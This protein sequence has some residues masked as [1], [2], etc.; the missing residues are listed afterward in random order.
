[1]YAPALPVGGSFSAA[2]RRADAADGRPPGRRCVSGEENGRKRADG[3]TRLRGRSDL[4]RE[5]RAQ[6][7]PLNADF[8]AVDPAQ[9]DALAIPGGPTPEYLRL[10]ERL[11]QIVRHFA[12][13]NKPLAAICHAAQILVAAGVVA[14]LRL[15]GLPAVKPGTWSRAGALWRDVNETF[16]NAVAD[17]NL[18]TAAAWPGHPEWMRK[19][20]GG[21]GDEDRAV[22]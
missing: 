18:V 8:D 10:N 20:L 11:L 6:P 3:R 2:F 19:F 16:S 13:A 14:G 17:G 4:Q 12:Q 1:M 7:Q 5:A 22:A 9:Y 15:P 21:A